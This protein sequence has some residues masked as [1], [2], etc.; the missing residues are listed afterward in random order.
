MTK[1]V[2]YSTLELC[3]IL[4][5]DAPVGIVTDETRVND[6]LHKRESLV[7]KARIE[8]NEKLLEDGEDDYEK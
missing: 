8:I 6:W 5:E 1:L 3:V 7:A 2:K 4:L